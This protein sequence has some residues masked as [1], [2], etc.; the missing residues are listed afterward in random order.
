MVDMMT[1]ESTSITEV[2]LLNWASKTTKIRNIAAPKAFD[3]KAPAS[4]CSWS[5]PASL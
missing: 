3:R 4:F 1:A 2:N 5:S